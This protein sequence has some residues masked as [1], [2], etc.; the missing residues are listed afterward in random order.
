MRLLQIIFFLIICGSLNAQTKPNVL[1]ILV[2]DFGSRDLGCYGSSLYETPNMDRLAAS[3]ARLTQAYVAYPRC[4]P[5]RFGIFTGKHPARVQG[6][7][8][9]PHVE[10]GRDATIGEAFAAAGYQTFYCGKWHLGEGASHPDQVGFTTSVAAGAAGAARS[11]FAPY[12]VSKGKGGHE[13]KDAITGLDDAPE[14][15]Y[16]TDRLTEETMKFIEANRDQPFCAVLAHYA[17]HTP[18]EGKKHLTKRYEEKLATLPKAAIEWEKESAGENLLVQNN[19]TYA[20]MIESVDNGVGRLLNQLQK[21]GIADHTIVIL[22]SDHG[23]L[24]ARGNNRG[25]ATSNRP[26]RAGKGHLY[27]GGLRIPMLLRWPGAVKAG[28]TIDTPVSTLDLM[29]T[30]AAMAGIAL[31]EKA[32]TDGR[33]LV[34]LLQGGAAPARD[35]FFWHN[36]SPR[37]GST[38]DLF[39]SAIREGDLKLIDFPAEKRI[40]LYDLAAD[41]GE[42]NNLADSKPEDRDRLLAKLNAWRREVGAS[43]EP[44]A[45]KPKANR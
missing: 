9:S 7:K 16:L 40:E 28:T 15:E 36:P 33:N 30:L 20:A 26:L 43:I 21:L 1:F 42:A 32:G 13:E 24:S 18:I 34:P 8:D 22:A 35:A 38:G 37:P 45:V 29:P 11:H 10:P 17:V 23:G 31:P 44:K 12:N 6:E 41:P 5:S 2:D 25:V 14:G 19:A 27:E 4:V 3:G 39:S